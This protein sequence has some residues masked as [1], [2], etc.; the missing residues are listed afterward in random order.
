MIRS[1]S[2]I[3]CFMLAIWLAS[4]AMIASASDRKTNPQARV[5]TTNICIDSL[6]VALIGTESLVAVSALA[7]DDRYSQISDEV[8]DLQKVTFNAEIIYALNPSL[9]LASNFSSAKTKSA[10]KK[11]GVNVRLIS[12]AR[13]VED[14]EKNI[15]ILGKLL[16]AESRA[17]EL[18]RLLKT[19]KVNVKNIKQLIALQY[20]TNRFVHGRNSLISSIIRRSGFKS[21]S[22]FLGYNQGRYISAE[23]LVKSAPDVL[24]LDGDKSFS[25]KSGSPLY[26]PAL[27]KANS[28]TKALFIE[29]KHWSCGTPKVVDL[30]SS[31]S[32]EYIKL[33]GQNNAS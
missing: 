5:I 14:I 18:T 27:L 25:D 22:E 10:L 31:L 26:H 3:T 2:I 33:V 6:V 7:N 29:T 4:I 16:N 9:V 13:S 32:F 20:S 23:A 28:K 21:Y 19:P 12:F 15:F 11:L 8:K 30:I 24:I 17:Q 1:S